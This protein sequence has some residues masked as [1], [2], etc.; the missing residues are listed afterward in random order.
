MRRTRNR[1]SLGR[2]VVS[3]VCS[4]LMVLATGMMALTLPLAVADAD[5]GLPDVT[6]HSTTTP[7]TNA[8]ATAINVIAAC[9]S[10]STLFGGGAFERRITSASDVPGNGLKLNGTIPS[11][12]SGNPVADG[13]TTPSNWTAVAGF[14]GQSDTGDQATA[15]AN[16]ATGGPAATVIKVSAPVGLATQGNPP[17][18]TTA[19]CPSGTSL[20]SGGALG[21][22]ASEPSFKP[23]ASYPSDSSGNPVADG[24]TNPRSW[25]AYGSAG[26]VFPDEQVSAFAV[27][28]TDATINTQVTRIDA[29]G[30]QLGTTFTTTTATCATGTRLLGGGVLADQGLNVEPQQGVH[31]RGSFPSDSSGNAAADGTFNTDSWTGVVQAGGQAT[32]GTQARVF[33]MCVPSSVPVPAGAIGGILLTGLVALVFIGYQLARRPRP[34]RQPAIS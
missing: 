34:L 11:D 31:L 33:A 13:A 2:R 20:L 8:A 9:P 22:P 6:I 1:L 19:T 10:G 16:C 27:C 12:S 17:N 3:L 7:M 29:T 30:P 15:F 14:G 28:S 5:P 32:P 24:T 21:V 4:A 18:T 23:I 26:Q 25:T